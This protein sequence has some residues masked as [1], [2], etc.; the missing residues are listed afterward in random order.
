MTRRP[1]SAPAEA[2]S[3]LVELHA[4]ERQGN[5]Q[6]AVTL[7]ARLRALNPDLFA[8]YMQNRTT[9]YLR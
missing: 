9:R 1:D 7:R 8:L 3:L 2:A 6:P 5:P 4:L